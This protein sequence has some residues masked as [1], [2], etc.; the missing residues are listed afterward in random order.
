MAKL[1]IPRPEGRAFVAKAGARVPGGCV[2]VVGYEI[3]R[4]L[5]Q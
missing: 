4:M 5:E 1:P 2:G 3:E